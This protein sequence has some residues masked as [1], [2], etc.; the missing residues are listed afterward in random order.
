MSYRH[1]FG[2]YLVEKG[3][4]TTD[5]VISAR[6]LQISNN[7]MFG[8]RAKDKGWLTDDISRAY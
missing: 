5:A 4:I 6:L 1:S 2:Q 8:Q 7:R 3:L